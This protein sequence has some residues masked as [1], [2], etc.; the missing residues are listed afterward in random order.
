MV[1]YQ[2]W[3]FGISLPRVLHLSPSAASAFLHADARSCIGSQQTS[4][5]ARTGERVVQVQPIETTHG[6]GS[7]ASFGEGSGGRTP[8]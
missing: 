8:S 4:Q 2:N 3:S 6:D 7:M 5:H 1:P